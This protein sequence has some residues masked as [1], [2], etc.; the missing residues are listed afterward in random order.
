MLEGRGLTR[1]GVT[2]E[3]VSDGLL[4]L[5]VRRGFLEALAQIVLKVLV[6]L[7]SCHCGHKQENMWSLHQDQN[8]GHY[9]VTKSQRVKI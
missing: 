4:Q 3:V 9:T 2:I 5:V 6:Q 8:S 1:H 7:A